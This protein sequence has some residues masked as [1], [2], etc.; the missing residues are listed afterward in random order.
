MRN[1]LIII[2]DSH[3]TGI[4]HKSVLPT[5]RYKYIKSENKYAIIDLYKDSYVATADGVSK[6]DKMTRSY[7]HCLKTATEVHIVTSA[8]LGGVSNM[9]QGF[10]ELVVKEGFA[11]NYKNK[12]LKSRFNKKNLYVYV[13]HKGD[14]YRFNPIWF[15]FKFIISKLF[16]QTKIIQYNYKG[17]SK[18]GRPEFLK[19]LNSKL[20]KWLF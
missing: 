4:N 15:R 3:R 8:H 17:I 11:Y 7:M 6:P 5:I 20:T 16:N 13:F 10:L 14:Y 19:K 9:L 12:T 1:A 2:A 18:I